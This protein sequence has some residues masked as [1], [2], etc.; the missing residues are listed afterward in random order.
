M[1]LDEEASKNMVCLNTF[2]LE[3]RQ[4]NMYSITIMVITNDDDYAEYD[5]YVEYEKNHWQKTTR[6]TSTYVCFPS[7]CMRDLEKE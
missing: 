2:H 3:R 4:P 7:K 6:H 1:S 5:D